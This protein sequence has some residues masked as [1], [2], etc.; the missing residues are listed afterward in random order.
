M[1]QGKFET[2]QFSASCDPICE[3]QA[4]ILDNE[5]PAIHVRKTI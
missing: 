2:N 1:L 3:L 4:F 5:I